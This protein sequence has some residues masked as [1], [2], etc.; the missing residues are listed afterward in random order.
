MTAIQIKQLYDRVAQVEH[1]DHARRSAQHCVKALLT[2]QTQTYDYLPY[3][4]SR[5]FEFEGSPRK[6]WWQFF[7]DNVGE[8]IEIWNFDLKIATFWIDSGKLKGVLESGS[9]EVISL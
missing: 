7:G 3:F 2:A 9:P 4:Y 5:V 1:V 8:T 6:I